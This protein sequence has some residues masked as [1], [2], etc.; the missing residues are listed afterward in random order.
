M[1]ASYN[2]FSTSNCWQGATSMAELLEDVENEEFENL[3]ENIDGYLQSSGRFFESC[4]IKEVLKTP[5]GIKKYIQKNYKFENAINLESSDIK[6]AHSYSVL[7][8]SKNPPAMELF[9][10]SVYLFDCEADPE[11]GL[12]FLKSLP[13]DVIKV[14]INDMN[15]NL[16]FNVFR[17]SILKE[18]KFINGTLLYHSK[19]LTVK[20]AKEEQDGVEA[21]RRAE[22]KVRKMEKKYERD[23]AK[24]QLEICCQL[25]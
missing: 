13:L 8:F 5:L 3:S 23:E 10:L 16:K 15:P 17:Q 2:T 25:F 18:K 24:L 9:F 12:P 11:L 20:A 22:R 14:I 1:E 21:L 7:K 6:E 19:F 4:D